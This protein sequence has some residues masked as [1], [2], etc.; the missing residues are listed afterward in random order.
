LT[1]VA[2]VI[3]IVLLLPLVAVAVDASQSGWGEVTS[4]LFRSRSVGLLVN[5][6]A[7][8][9]IVTPLAAAIGTA[10]AWYTERTAL[11]GRRIWT[12]LLVLPVAMPD[13]IVGYAWHS[14]APTASPLGAAVLVMTLSSYPVIYTATLGSGGRRGSAQSRTRLDG[15]VLPGCAPVNQ[16]SDSRRLPDYRSRARL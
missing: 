5:T 15:D 13:F 1:V 10:A 8:P 2:A 3:G 12:V 14:I 9:L 6:L 11:H 16:G 4:V 7:L